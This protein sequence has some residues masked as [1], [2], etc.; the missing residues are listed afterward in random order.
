M[1]PSSL[2]EDL[3][4]SEG[5]E[6]DAPNPLLDGYGEIVSVL[7]FPD[8]SMCIPVLTRGSSESLPAPT[9]RLP[10]TRLWK[11]RSGE[12]VK[13]LPPLEGVET[14]LLEALLDPSAHTESRF[15]DT[16]LYSS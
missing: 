3:R 11:S 15:S 12:G 4:E 14:E 7:S 5:V 10:D 6:V 1:E 9:G 2:V 8:R 16:T 13:S